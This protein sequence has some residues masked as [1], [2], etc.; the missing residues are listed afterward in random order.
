[1]KKQLTTSTRNEDQKGKQFT[2][3]KWMSEERQIFC[4]HC[5]ISDGG[6]CSA[7]SLLSFLMP[8]HHPSSISTI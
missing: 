6:K 8:V 1:M 7:L 5:I 4:T 3:A 2:A